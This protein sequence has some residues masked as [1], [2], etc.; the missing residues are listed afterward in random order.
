[1]AGNLSFLSNIVIKIIGAFFFGINIFLINFVCYIFVLDL[2]KNSIGWILI[3]LIL[4]IFSSIIMYANKVRKYGYIF[5]LLFLFFPH[6]V[7][8]FINFVQNM[9][10]SLEAGGYNAILS[11]IPFGIFYFTLSVMPVRIK[12]QL[13]L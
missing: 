11:A 6:I 8:I 3:P 7:R 12:N 9:N 4:F 13:I 1:M 2:F 5:A 10:I